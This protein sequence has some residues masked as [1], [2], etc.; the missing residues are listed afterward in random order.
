[1]PAAEP[2]QPIELEVALRKV[3]KREPLTRDERQ[4]V[5]RTLDEIPLAADSDGDDW[6]DVTPEEM[7]E[8]EQAASEAE[9]DLRAGRC[10]PAEKFF[11]DRGIPWPPARPG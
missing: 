1:M 8:L 11:A 7:A 10:L 4:L 2:S 3:A 5:L 6:S 9:E